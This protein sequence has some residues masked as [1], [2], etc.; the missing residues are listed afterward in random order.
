MREK[1]LSL[2][3]Q[4]A[5]G[6]LLQRQL[7]LTVQVKQVPNNLLTLNANKVSRLEEIS[8]LILQIRAPEL[9]SVLVKLLQLSYYTG[10]LPDGWR[11]AQVQLIL[12]KGS[13]TY[14]TI[15]QLLTNGNIE[16]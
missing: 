12:K 3:T 1:I 10:S 9:A 7:F 4:Q 5:R 15:V 16:N 6:K 8:A 2:D 14:A 13:N 11:K